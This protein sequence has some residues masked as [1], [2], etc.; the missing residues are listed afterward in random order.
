MNFELIANFPDKRWVG[1]E[2]FSGLIST[3]DL[4]K[5]GYLLTSSPVKLDS[6]DSKNLVKL[7]VAGLFDNAYATNR[8][9]KPW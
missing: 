3:K 9:L 8:Q 4:E 2:F 6:L 1:T 5:P 7:N